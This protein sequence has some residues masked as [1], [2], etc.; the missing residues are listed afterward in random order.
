MRTLQLNEYEQER[1]TI[2][3]Q[4]A[5][6]R[7]HPADVITWRGHRHAIGAGSSDDVDLFEEG[8]ALFVLA[9]NRS[10]DYCGLQVF[11]G[12]EEVAGTFLQGPG[13]PNAGYMNDL[14]AIYAAKRLANWCD[15]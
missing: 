12:G 9:R 7:Y 11:E 15:W 13:D 1:E 2:A 14:S 5:A 10:L 4:N 6:G 8:G 3:E